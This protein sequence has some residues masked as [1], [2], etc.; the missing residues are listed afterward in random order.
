MA[1]QHS[2]LPPL[3]RL[4]DELL[5]PILSG[6]LSS[7]QCTF[8][9]SFTQP[10]W[11]FPLHGAALDDSSHKDLSLKTRDQ[12]PISGLLW[13]CK[14][15]HEACLTLLVERYTFLVRI[16]VRDDSPAG[17]NGFCNIL[18]LRRDFRH[19]IRSL[20]LH[21]NFFPFGCSDFLHTFRSLHDTERNSFMYERIIENVN[22]LLHMMPGLDRIH[23]VWDL[24]FGNSGLAEA[25]EVYTRK[26]WRRL[27][28]EWPQRQIMWTGQ[29]MMGRFDEVGS[30]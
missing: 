26:L 24:Y 22:E 14:L 25:Q 20:V 28:Q 3:L 6:V 13:S 4:P 23:M 19:G 15:L 11:G 7:E 5:L 18:S 17:A 12:A 21:I 16:N 30:S 10:L 29:S 1:E 8:V 9:A 27:R 2:T